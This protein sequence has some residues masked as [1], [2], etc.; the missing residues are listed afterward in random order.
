M[1]Q[2]TVASARPPS[3][4]QWP[5][6]AGVSGGRYA[7]RGGRDQG[8]QLSALSALP[9]QP[10]V[11]LEVKFLSNRARSSERAILAV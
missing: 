7:A 9:D 3:A 2:S 8:R 11:A 1:S 6:R 10:G 4:A 5:A